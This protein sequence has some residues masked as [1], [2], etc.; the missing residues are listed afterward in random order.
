MQLKFKHKTRN[1]YIS[2][3][4]LHLFLQFEEIKAKLTAIPEF[5]DFAV[6]VSA[7]IIFKT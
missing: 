6:E 4:N 5:N 7:E 3:I 1:R 2:A